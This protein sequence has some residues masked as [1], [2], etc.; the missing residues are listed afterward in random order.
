[1]AGRFINF[2][3]VPLY[4]GR[5]AEIADY[6]QV[7]VMFSYAGFLAVIFTYGMETG[8]FNFA[9]KTDRPA[10]VF[11][12]ATTALLCSGL[13]LVLL[14]NAFADG[15][16]NLAGYP[17]KPE[18]AVW[19]TAIIAADAVTS[20]G[21]AWLRFAERPWRFAAIRL[22]NIAINVGANLFFLIVCPWLAAHGYDW[23]HRIWSPARLVDYIFI[24]N[25]L[26]S[27]ITIPLMAGVWKNLKAGFQWTLF[28]SMLAY[29]LPMVIVGLAGMVNET[30]DRVLIKQLLPENKADYEAGIYGAFY[31]LSMV[32]TLFVQA[33]RFA[34]EPF[35]FKQADEAN[36]PRT[37][38]RVMTT[39][40]YVCGLIYVVT[41][42]CLPWLGPLLIRNEAYFR[43]PRGM[44]IVPV[45]LLANLMLG[46]YYN[47]SVWYKLSGKTMLGAWTA[48]FGA[49][50]TLAGNFIWLGKYSFLASAWTTLAAYGGMVLLGYW[51]GQRYYPVPYQRGRVFVVILAAL[52]LGYLGAQYATVV[53][54]ISALCVAAYVLMVWYL[55]AR[56]RLNAD[57]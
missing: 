27:V 52:L 23:V 31:K 24:S 26:A 32:M 12:T 57:K 38:A 36:A 44:A 21:F 29:S 42:A 47:L 6:G 18:Y 7:N 13:L 55:E 35:F 30:L 51:L 46:I 43:D 40:V 39:F 20:L 5:L 2:L 56:R 11:S 16:M 4:T 17:A 25:L 14:G 1:M 41:M 37:Y 50:I 10:L 15:L 22:A 28:R 33:F 9:R 48:L 8:F 3:L 53:P 45:L 49:V 19:F 54:F 34:A